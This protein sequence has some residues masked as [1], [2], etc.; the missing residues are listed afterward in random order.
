MNE[1]K[2]GKRMV[3]HINLKRCFLTMLVVSLLVMVFGV[4]C[5]TEQTGQPVAVQDEQQAIITVSGSGVDGTHEFQVSE[6]KTWEDSQFEHI[7][8]TINNWPSPKKYAVRGIK[9]QKIL[10]A[11][12]LKAPAKSFTFKSDDGFEWSFTREQLLETPQ[13][14]FPGVKDGDAQNPEPVEPV[15]AYE[16]LEGSDDMSKAAAGDPCL[17]VGQANV[18][19]QT[20]ITFVINVADIVVSSDDPGQWQLPTIFPAPGQI[21]SGETVKLEHNEI[22]KVKMY[23]T[24]DGSTPTENST[25]YNPSTYQPELNKP[26]PIEKDTTIKV[27]VKGFGKDDSDIATF[28]YKVE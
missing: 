26:I 23:Y 8:S 21:A 5:S 11:A 28:E 14:Y 25:L 2:E 18:K 19:E 17:I 9:L 10:E 7:Y 4:G 24:L 22:G 3:K 13:F 27:L 1:R 12:G 6:M 20:N 16:Y 15:I